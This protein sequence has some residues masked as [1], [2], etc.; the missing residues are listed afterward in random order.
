MAYATVK[1]VEAGF[2][3]LSTDEAELCKTLLTEA[4]I[5]IDAYNSDAGVDAK[6]LVSCRM[7]RRQIGAGS[8]EVYPLGTTQGSVSAMGYSQ[9]WTMGSGSVGELYLSKT[10]KKLLG[11]GNK[12]GAHSVLEDM[13]Y[14]ERD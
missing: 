8:D 10:E 7:V 14:A 13:C 12:I 6:W 11:Y 4:A 2:R 3:T 9:S 5:L 1:D